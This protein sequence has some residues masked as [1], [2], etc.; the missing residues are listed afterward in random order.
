[1]H[2]KGRPSSKAIEREFLHVVEVAV[3]LGGLGKRLDAMHDFHSVC[4][5]KPCLGRGR[6]EDDQDHLRWYFAD[7]KTAAMF[8]EKFGGKLSA[9]VGGRFV[10][11]VP[12]AGMPVQ[13]NGRRFSQG[14]EP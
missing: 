1:M 2:Y 9:L 14:R 13:Q 3:P 7:P 4:G 6:R 8:A 10:R 12:H 11:E 5:I